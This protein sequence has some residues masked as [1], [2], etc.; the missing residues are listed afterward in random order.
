MDWYY[1]KNGE[2]HGPVSLADLRKLVREGA[3]GR[4]DKVWTPDF[5]GDWRDVRVV[6]ELCDGTQPTAPPQPPTAAG[7]VPSSFPADP[8]TPNRE[9]TQ[10]ARISLKGY[11]G[12]VVLTLFIWQ[13]IAVCASSGVPCLGPLAVMTVTGAVQFGFARIFLHTARGIPPKIENLFD[14]FS[15]FGNT[16]AAYALTTLFIFLWS[17]LLLI[18]GIIASYSY[19]Q[20]YFILADHP[21]LSASEAIRRSKTMMRGYRWK[22]FCLHCRFIGWSLLALL[23]TLGIGLFW[24]QAYSSTAQA[25]FYETIK[26]RV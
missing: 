11:W 24:V 26:E 25:H 23:F 4:S 17:L 21:N 13:V 9:L 7:P 15:F 18:P 2:S 6:P 16:L 14:G 10:R 8:D 20:V 22:L 12:T 5:G 3:V 1:A 19:A